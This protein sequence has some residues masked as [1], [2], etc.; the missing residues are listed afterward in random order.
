[1]ND[2]KHIDDD[3]KD[4][5]DIEWISPICFDAQ[6]SS[7]IIREILN[8]LKYKF[9]REKSEKAYSQL[10]FLFTV[11]K[12]AYVFRFKI[13]EPS[14]FTIDIY[15]THP[16]TSGVMTYME[17]SGINEKNIK[18]IRK[19][20]KEFAKRTPRKPWEFTFGQR[21]AHGILC[22]EFSKSKKAWR[23]MGIK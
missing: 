17:I 20:L 13:I 4:S 8:D 2:K 12:M 7:I 3:V 23:N 22:L 21:V 6:S 16:S 9:R 14:K 10:Y 11:P 5:E 1:M 18:Y 19:I 15:D